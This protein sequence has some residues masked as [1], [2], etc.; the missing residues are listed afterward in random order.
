MIVKQLPVVVAWT[1]QVAATRPRSREARRPAK[2]GLSA[3]PG[4]RSVECT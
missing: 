4:M 1:A 3:L 2:Q